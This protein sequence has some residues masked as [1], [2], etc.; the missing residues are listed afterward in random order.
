M[1]KFEVYSYLD[2]SGE[3]VDLQGGMRDSNYLLGII[4]AN[5]YREAKIK[6]YEEYGICI[7]RWV[8]KDG[9]EGRADYDVNEAIY[10]IM[11]NEK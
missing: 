11:K 6:A 7:I 10:K 5:T 3:E 8:R 9:Y 1:K 2:D 4:E